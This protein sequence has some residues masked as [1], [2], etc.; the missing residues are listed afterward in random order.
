LIPL[1]LIAVDLIE[2]ALEISESPDDPWTY[3]G[4]AI[5]A[6]D[7]T[8]GNVVKRTSPKTL[9]EMWKRANGKVWPRARAAGTTM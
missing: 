9:R 7:P 8:P 5:G 4:V 3:V 1:A 6:V 2:T